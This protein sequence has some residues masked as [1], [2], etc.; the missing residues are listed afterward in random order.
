MTLS[1]S[2]GVRFS[3]ACGMLIAAGAAEAGIGV[4]TV[5]P[6]EPGCD[7]QMTF[8][9]VGNFG[10]GCWSVTDIDFVS[11]NESLGF[12]IY[13]VDGWQPGGNCSTVIV[14]Y[15]KTE[16]V[17]PPPSGKY[18]GLAV[19]NVQSLREEGDQAFVP[20]LACCTGNEA[21]VTDLRLEKANGGATL[22]FTWTNVPGAENFHLYGGD[23]PDG[24]FDSQLTSTPSLAIELPLAHLPAYFL[25]SQSSECGEGSRH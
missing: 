14:E 11:G 24:L 10:D 5:E 2:S 17:D 22:R 6:S 12:I 3:I 9:V 16:V 21:S 8:H 19:E 7:E 4:F 23:A 13:A 1:F 25:L 20:V 18:W 15:S